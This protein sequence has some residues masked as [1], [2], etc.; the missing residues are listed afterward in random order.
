MSGMGAG[1]VQAAEVTANATEE[2]GG[3]PVTLVVW[4]YDWS[5]INTNSDTYVVEELC[6]ALEERFNDRLAASA[7]TRLMDS[8]MAALFERGVS[9]EALA[10][11]VENVPIYPGCLE[12]I[13]VCGTA[14]VEQVVLS[15][16]NTFFIEAC[17]QRL[18]I[19]NHFSQVIS[20]F[21]EFDDKGRL[22]ITEFSRGVPHGCPLCP[23]N[24]C[25][26][27]VLEQ[28]RASKRPDRIIYV[29]DGGGDFCPAC[30]LRPGDSVLCRAPPSPPLTHFGLHRSIQR[31]L[32]ASNGSKARVTRD[33]RPAAV[34]AVVRLWHSGDDVAA[35][36][37]EI[38]AETT[39]VS[40][41]S[42]V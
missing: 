21:G 12:A 2:K 26:G 40:A 28:L 25:K 8:L 18:G 22:H 34:A 20:N 30:D 4:D 41:A 3:P 9:R 14:G 23:P 10:Q 33:G 15:D 7:W 37:K 17:L 42:P 24:L 35:I 16:A 27:A 13:R 32:E 1:E 5:L 6:P 11:C 38:L 36:F 19:R 29:G 31:S 39:K